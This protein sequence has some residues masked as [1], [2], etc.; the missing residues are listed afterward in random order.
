MKLL[1]IVFC[2]LCSLAIVACDSVYNEPDPDTVAITDPTP[3]NVSLTQVTLYGNANVKKTGATTNECTIGIEWTLASD[4]EYIES[5]KSISQGVVGSMITCDLHN[6]RPNTRYIYRTYVIA[7]GTTYVGSTAEFET[8]SFGNIAEALSAQNIS[9]TTADVSIRV[10]TDQMTG[11][12]ED[13]ALYFVGLAF[14]NNE[15]DLYPDDEGKLHCRVDTVFCGADMPYKDYTFQAHMDAL[16]AGT[17]YYYCAYTSCNGVS[18]PGSIHTLNTQAGTGTVNGQSWVDLAL[19]SGTLWATAN[20][21]ATSPEQPGTYFAWG[22]TASKDAYTWENYRYGTRDNLTR[23]NQHDQLTELQ[24]EDDAA[25]ATLGSG[26]RMPSDE[27]IDELLTECRWTW[28]T[29]KGVEGYT[30]LG[31]NKN[32]IF[33]PITGYYEGTELKRATSAGFFWSR[34]AAN[35]ADAQ[36]FYIGISQSDRGCDEDLRYYG[37][38]IRPIYEN[39]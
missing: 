26:W 20:V 11:S 3:R 1:K 16:S 30:V 22:E 24:P 39:E 23:Y 4:D 17:L 5:T 37:Q 12:E 8:Q 14:A 21:G 15:A 7:R 19:P 33:L 10:N 2:S 13:R 34:T 29:Y 9:T 25:R 6:L 32:S 35:N 31:T 28:T 38:P 27:Q 36:S 18:V